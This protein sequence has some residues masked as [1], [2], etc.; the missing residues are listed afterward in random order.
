ML[1][2]DRK[3]TDRRSGSLGA[4]SGLSALGNLRW[5]GLSAP[6]RD[7]GCWGARG[8][9]AGA[10]SPPEAHEHSLAAF[11]ASCPLWCCQVGPQLTWI[12]SS[13]PH[14]SG[15]GR[16]P[17]TAQGLPLARGVK[18]RGGSSYCTP[19]PTPM[20]GHHVDVTRIPGN[21]NCFC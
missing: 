14:G 18:D 17:R 2:V 6:G 4:R 9:T 19:R 21:P 8:A 11:V 16:S 10:G 12:Q 5:A 7:Q 15:A 13:A 1:E 3:M 20:I